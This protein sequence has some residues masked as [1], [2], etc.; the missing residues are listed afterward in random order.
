M[1][2]AL[3]IA[4]YIVTKCYNDGKP[5]TN[6]KL[7]KILFYVQR[8]YLNAGKQAFSDN[9]EAWMYG[10]V[11][12][13]VYYNYCSSGAMPILNVDENAINNIMSEDQKEINE[14]VE[15][16][17]DY[18][19]WRLVEMTHIEGGAW[20]KAFRAKGGYSVIPT[21]DIKECPIGV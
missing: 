6:L 9:I 1:Y 19:V 10:P 21:N 12:S 16:Y 11:V 4:K 5:I 17:R 18:D 14:V 15:K 20:D 13:D 3:D 7:Q 2:K 8:K